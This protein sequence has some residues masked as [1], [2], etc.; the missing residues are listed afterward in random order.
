MSGRTVVR[1]SVVVLQGQ[2][3]FGKAPSGVTFLTSF[4]LT[5]RYVIGVV[6]EPTGFMNAN[7]VFRDPGGILSDGA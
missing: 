1:V 5:R 7:L 4:D 6:L 2:F 3:R